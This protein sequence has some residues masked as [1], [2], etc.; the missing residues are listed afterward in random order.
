MQCIVEVGA[1]KLSSL[2]KGMDTVTF[3]FLC[4]L[5]ISLAGIG[6]NIFIHLKYVQK[7]TKAC[8]VIHHSLV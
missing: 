7:N 3:F 6:A 1:F 4:L 8:S 5:F 2:P